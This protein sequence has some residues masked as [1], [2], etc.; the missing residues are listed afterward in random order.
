M[1][2]ATKSTTTTSKWYDDDYDEV[3]SDVQCE[4]KNISTFGFF[5]FYTHGLF[6]TNSQLQREA[7]ARFW[8]EFFL[9][10]GDLIV[11]ECFGDLRGCLELV[12]RDKRGQLWARL[13]GGAM[14]G[15][16]N[17]WDDF[18]KVIGTKTIFRAICQ[19]YGL[20]TDILS[21][22]CSLWMYRIQDLESEKSGD[23]DEPVDLTVIGWNKKGL[24][25]V[26]LFGKDWTS[27]VRAGRLNDCQGHY[28]GRNDHFSHELNVRNT[29]EPRDVS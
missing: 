16:D 10:T 18:V 7:R 9:K 17:S 5:T 24:D 13:D 22:N 2:F 12:P 15:E 25:G 20:E 1:S 28:P 11:I 26:D 27:D 6:S 8:M 21:S 3:D 23:L 29:P 14:V 19:A 4:C